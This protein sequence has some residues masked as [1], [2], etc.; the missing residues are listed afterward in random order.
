MIDD[1]TDSDSPTDTDTGA[2]AVAERPGE[3]GGAPEPAELDPTAP[4]LAS[5][6]P[7]NLPPPRPTFA[8][9]LAQIPVEGWITGG[10]VAM[11]VVF[12]FAQLH[13]SL[14]LSDTTPAG[15]DMG[16]HVWAP[17]YLRDTLLPQGRLTGWTPD[18]YAGFPAFQFYMILPSLAIALLSFLIPYG[19][20]FKLVAVSGVV[21]MPVSAYLFGRLS[22]LPV[23]APAL[24][25]VAATLYLFDRSFS[26]YGGNIASTLAG[27]FAFSISLSFALVY[28]GMLSRTLETGRHRGWTALLLALT[29]LCHLIPLIFVL[30][31]T[32]IWFILRPG[33]GQAIV[34]ATVLPVAGALT[35]FWTLPFVF[36][37]GYMNDMGWEKITRYGDYLWSRE[38][39]DPQLINVPDIKWI[40]ALAAVGL[41]LSLVYRRRAGVFLA[42]VAGAMALGFRYAPDGRVWNARLLPFYYLALYL[43]AAVGVAELARLLAALFA[44]DVNKP[45]RWLPVGAAVSSL[46]VITFMVSMSMQN[47]PGGK[48]TPEGSYQWPAQIGGVSWPSALSVSTTDKGFV[49]SWADWNFTGYEGVSQL[50]GGAEQYRKSYPE[51]HDIVTTM[52]D[53]GAERGCGRA[54]WEHEEQHD[55]Y[56][57]PMALML[58]P[59]W[60]DGCIGSMEGLY[61]EASSTTPYHFL[62]QDE[63]SY[64]PSNAQRDLPYDPGP[65]DQTEFDEGVAHLQMMGVR[66]YMAINDATKALADQ[67]TD[68]DEIATSGPWTIFEV[69]D[70]PL[71]VGLANQPAV[72]SGQRTTGKEWQKLAVC[73][74]EDRDNWDI[75]L[76]QDGPD[77]WQRVSDTVPAPADATPAQ[78]CEPT[79]NWG[80]FSEDGGPEVRP[81]DP[82]DVTNVET[83]TDTISFDVSEPGVPVLVKASYFP[84]W[85]V[86]GGAGPYRVTPNFMVVVPD[87][88]HVELT[89]GYTPIDYLGYLLTIIGIIGLVY[90]FRARPVHVAPPRR[91]WGKAERPDLYPSVGPDLRFDDPQFESD[92]ARALAAIVPERT[93]DDIFATPLTGALPERPPT[94]PGDV[95][96]QPAAPTVPGPGS[97][98]TAAAWATPRPDA[99]PA[100]EPSASADPPPTPSAADDDPPDP[101]PFQIE[102]RDR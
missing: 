62:N 102:D 48:L 1:L 28:L 72:L 81:Q 84:N 96:D 14:L 27:E 76:A 37:V 90:L 75:Y 25:S 4:P 63:L 89:F 98:D 5:D 52:G 83:G 70:A 65:P 49:G 43:L 32:V 24:L 12:V 36:R 73:W 77:D 20:A 95:A 58:L 29:G 86:S 15:G 78:E 56:G 17:A 85:Q 46:F 47:M 94:A 2:V 67:N 10:I 99:A 50:A 13:P 59:F 71:V 55:R 9:R 26:I 23:P 11:C 91:F 79:A 57:T 18:W 6:D 45:I 39:L 16:A 51:Y 88:N 31:G 7:G 82:V 44:R 8:N 42:L 66:Y 3:R 68:L 38:G 61:F 33:K 64:A 41:L 74:Y 34:L 60:T 97:S 40:I 19:T 93:A 54:M 87:S 21:S 69:Q 100:A 101:D 35:A 30:V 22:R 80:W 53:I 92:A